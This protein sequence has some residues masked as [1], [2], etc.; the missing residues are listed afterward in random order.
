[1]SPIDL[2]RLLYLF[3]PTLP[4]GGFTYS[5]GLEWA[6]EGGWVHDATTAQDW[7]HSQLVETLSYVDVPMMKRLHFALVADNPTTAVAEAHLLLAMR[8]TAELRQEERQRAAALNRVLAVHLS[9]SPT[10]QRELTRFSESLALTPL[11][12]YCVLGQAWSLPL[13]AL[14]QGYGW[15]WL[16]G[17]VTAAV[18]LVPLGQTVGQH[19]L[20]QLMPILGLAV[21]Q[22]LKR[23]DDE[24]GSSQPRLAIASSRH[25]T[26][27][28]RLFRS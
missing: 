21:D 3:S 11:M 18:K 19:L 12:G 20:K 8:E 10:G 1:M 26:Q 4:I 9:D 14:G 22:G 23:L 25:E 13:A 24:L 15:S 28:S 27:Y 7:L 2:T 17:Q 16:D 5:Q 6:V